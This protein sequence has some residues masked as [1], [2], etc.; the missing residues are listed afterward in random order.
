MECVGFVPV[1]VCFGGGSALAGELLGGQHNGTAAVWCTGAVGRCLCST[2]LGWGF[3]GGGALGL[4]RISVL[5][6]TA[7]VRWAGERCILLTKWRR[8]GGGA[9]GG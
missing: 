3:G 5:D 7:T 8:G 9:G 2:G 4:L 1:C 6:S